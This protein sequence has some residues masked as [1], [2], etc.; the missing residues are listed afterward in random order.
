MGVRAAGLVLVLS[1]FGATAVARAGEHWNTTVLPVDAGQPS[2]FSEPGITAGPS[3]V[4]VANAS[5]ANSG[6]P[7]TFWLSHD[8]GAGWSPGRPVGDPSM[9][10]GD[11]DAAIAPDGT[12]YALILGYGSDPSQPSNPTVLVYRSQDGEHW[13]GPASFPP[14]HGADQPDRP[15]LVVPH[16]APGEVLV[17]NSEGGGNVVEW[18]STDHGAS[19]SGPTPVTGGANS[20]AVITLGSRPLVDPTDSSRLFLFYETAGVEPLGPPGALGAMSA[21]FPLTQ[22]WV[23]RSE[24]GGNSW[25]NQLVHDAGTA[26]A[27]L[28]PASAVDSAGN[29]YAVVSERAAGGTATQLFIT[30][31]TDHGA[32][33]STP[34]PIA[35][36][37][38]S[39]V[40]PALAATGRGRLVVSWYASESQD[41]S[42][43]RARWHQ[44]VA[45]GSDALA[46]RPH[47][48]GR[49]IGGPFPLHIGAID[50]AGAVGS[51]AGEN[52]ALRDFQS[53][54]V[55]HCGRPHV[56]WAADN[57]APATLTATL[58]APCR[59]GRASGD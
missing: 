55:D 40:M 21:E 16:G 42:D 28:L 33:W 18:R 17:F 1:L 46:A 3:G 49:S 10:T 12:M 7:A 56:T 54:T 51:D 9:A 32:R 4:M 59:P 35:A 47:F 11:S 41:F 24:D 38:P 23:A 31:S 22:L 20:E 48:A 50:N 6:A 39:N 14:P 8:D 15:W 27:H 58:Q 43:A 34:A 53:V 57:P 44:M 30:H 26:L 52:W 37:A 5:T 25:N 45:S 2:S 36:G 19:F 13:D 29:V